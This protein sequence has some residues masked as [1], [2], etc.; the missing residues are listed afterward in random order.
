[1]PA[2]K[3][4]RIKVCFRQYGYALFPAVLLLLG[5]NERPQPATP[6]TSATHN[7]NLTAGSQGT[8]L[9]DSISGKVW[10]YSADKQALVEVPVTSEI[11][12]YVRD[13]DGK[14]VRRE[15]PST[16]PL[17]ILD[18]QYGEGDTKTNSAGDH[19][20]FRSGKWQ[21]DQDWKTH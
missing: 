18:R 6:I 10:Q 11:I 9:V 1:M 3:Q 17:G 5:C 7:F 14:I 13:N 15:A 2:L 19:V 12:E 16:D 21:L 8:F 4:A 20:I